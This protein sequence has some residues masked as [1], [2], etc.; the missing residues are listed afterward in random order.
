MILHIKQSGIYYLVHIPVH[1]SSMYQAGKIY[2]T[3]YIYHCARLP[4]HRPPRTRRSTSKTK[5]TIQFCHV[6]ITFNACPIPLACYSLPKTCYSS[7][8]SFPSQ[9]HPHPPLLPP[10][11][12]PLPFF[13]TITSL[14]CLLHSRF[15]SCPS[16]FYHCMF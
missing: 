5:L 4:T 3:Q 7:F 8:S 1:H 9:S 14:P 6:S 16:P 11:P 12:P 13:F 2:H 10:L 15:P